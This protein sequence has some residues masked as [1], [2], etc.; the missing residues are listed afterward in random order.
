MHLLL[1]VIKTHDMLHEQIE[2]GFEI[3]MATVSQW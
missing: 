3:K 1:Q 2:I